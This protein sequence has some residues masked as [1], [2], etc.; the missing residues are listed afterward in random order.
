MTL[1]NDLPLRDLQFYLTAPYPCSYLPD[2]S[3]RSQVAAP[4]YLVDDAVYSTLIQAGFR[5]SGL[6]TYRPHCDACRACTPVRVDVVGFAPG[7]TQRRALK[8]HADLRAEVKP[9]TFAP[10]HYALYRRYQSARHPG[11]GMDQ[12]DEEQYRQFLLQSNV[13]TV[14]IEFRDEAALRMVSV[15]DQVQDGLS[16]VYTFYDPDLSQ[17]SF[18]TYNILWQIDLCRQL[19]LPYLYLGYWIEHSRKMAYKAA[20]QPLQAFTDGGWQP[21][22]TP[23]PSA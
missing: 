15:V 23:S 16:S 11:G 14:L 9:L 6:Y 19:G 18:G 3:A 20:F 1:L 5:R 7:R 12:D 4:N 21:M 2:R 17:A 10:E 13:T 22:A 8:R